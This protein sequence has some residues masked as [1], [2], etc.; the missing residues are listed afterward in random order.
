MKHLI[1][2]LLAFSLHQT[3]I[4]QASRIEIY[5]DSLGQE[6]TWEAHWAQVYTGRYKSVFDKTEKQNILVK[7]SDKELQHE[8]ARTKHLITKKSRLGTNLHSFRVTDIYGKE[9]STSDLKGKVIVLNFWYIGCSPCEMERLSL[10]ELKQSYSNNSNVVFI[11][12]TTDT[13]NLRAYL[14]TSPFSYR[15]V[16][17]SKE[18]IK[19]TF[20]IKVCPESFVVDPNGRISFHASGTGIG[21]RQILKEQIEKS[22]GKADDEILMLPSDTLVSSPKN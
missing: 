22:L 7:M 1:F 9:I 21:I 20:D 10:N 2:I 8:L 17:K 15:I 14:K 11:S 5:I 18:F 4:A 19:N 6:T 12:F 13:A 3:A 16:S